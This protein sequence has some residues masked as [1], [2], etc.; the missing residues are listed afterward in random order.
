MMRRLAILMLPLIF[1]FA[2]DAVTTSFS[3]TQ[4]TAEA[5]TAETTATYMTTTFL[6]TTETTIPGTTAVTTTLPPIAV[7][8]GLAMSSAAVLTWDPVTGVDT[9]VLLVDDEEISVSGCVYDMSSYPDDLYTIRVKAVDGV[10]QSAY[11]DAASFRILLHPEV[12]WGLSI[13]GG[14][15]VWN[16]VDGASGYRVLVNGAETDVTDTAYDLSGLEANAYYV[17]MVEACF[18]GGF[19]SDPSVELRYHTYVDLQVTLDIQY[20][21]N[22]PG[23]LSVDLTEHAWTLDGLVAPED[24]L[25]PDDDWD[26]TDGVLTIADFYL[27]SLSYGEKEF[28]LLTPEGSALLRLA[29]VDDRQPYMVSSS[30]VTFTGEDIWLEF[31][32]YDGEIVSVSGNDIAVSDYAI[33][34]SLLVIDAAYVAAKFANEPERTVLILGYNLSANTNVVIGYIFIRLPSGD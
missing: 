10:R 29:V 13:A 20:D 2:C 32:L 8:T 21:K 26:Y 18:D 23:D 25:L 14:F 33:S 3:T 5:S 17:L 1:L 31:E 15:L 7:P 16:A 6:S 4:T 11:S 12:P 34:D 27:A 9:Y 28:L 22:D 19:V 30:Q 24:Y